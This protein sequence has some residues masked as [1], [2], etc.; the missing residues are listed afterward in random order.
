MMVQ[1]QRQGQATRCKDVRRH[2]L[3]E[4]WSRGMAPR[5]LRQREAPRQRFGAIETSSSFLFS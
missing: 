3:R 2:L 4:A 5:R 1:R